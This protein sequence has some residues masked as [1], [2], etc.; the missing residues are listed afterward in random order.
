MVSF[1]H[2]FRVVPMILASR[3]FAESLYLTTPAPLPPDDDRFVFITPYFA[4]L[5]TNITVSISKGA[6][7]KDLPGG[8]GYG[9]PV[10]TISVIPVPVSRGFLY[11][12]KN[13]FFSDAANVSVG[14]DGLLSSSDSSST[15]QIT[16]ILTELAQA[17]AFPFE[18]VLGPETTPPPKPSQDQKDRMTCKDMIN[19]LIEQMPY[20][21]S[22]TIM[23][24]KRT[25]Y[26]VYYDPGDPGS[27][28]QKKD[29]RDFASISLRLDIPPVV[30]AERVTLKDGA[31]YGLVAFYPVPYRNT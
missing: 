16:A 9:P 28:N 10:L 15:Q 21:K 22:F 11:L 1:K 2:L 12:T 23:K 31:H 26:G 7:N 14:S 29:K 24:I 6:F 30:S 4:E 19:G 20:Y 17:A 5:K 3:C 8:G 13:P 27:E 18:V 25:F